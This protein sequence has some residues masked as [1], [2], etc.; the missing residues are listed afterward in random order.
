MGHNLN[1]NK[2]TGT[3]SFASNSEKA[4][5]GL[6]QV[7]DGA[8]TSKEAIEKANLDYEVQKTP[9]T[10]IVGPDSQQIEIPGYYATYRTDTNEPL[11]MV[12]SRYEVVQNRDAFSFFD[13]IIDQGEA[14]FETAGALGK[15]EKIFITAKLPEDIL[16]GGEAVNQYVLLHNSH[17]GTSSVVAGLTSVRVVCNNTLQAALSSLEN[18]VCISHTNKASDRL[19]EAVRV[20]GIAS[21]Y[22]QQVEEMFNR[23]TDHRMTEGEYRDFFRD[24]F[25]T[26]YRVKSLEEEELNSTR[27][28]NMVDGATEFAMTHPTQT[29][30]ETKGTLWGAYNAVSGFYGYVRKF[31]TEEARFS[32]QFF[33]AANTKM[34]KSFT[35]AAQLMGNQLN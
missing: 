8:M 17:D 24:V 26:E 33:G 25:K 20:M 10:M 2:A 12:K 19:R 3:W 14:I 9:A 28:K 27:L 31:P 7:V 16:V 34:L 13:S 23:M 15:G 6:G 32:S 35:R 22:S 29:T 11:G 5:H 21:K 4:W 1:F 30:P 18:R